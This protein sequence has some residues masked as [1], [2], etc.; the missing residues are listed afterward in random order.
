MDRRHEFPGGIE[1]SA[2]AE[3]KKIG[4]RGRG[5]TDDES[6]HSRPVR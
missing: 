2:I 6:I 1:L 5:G 4:V 3:L